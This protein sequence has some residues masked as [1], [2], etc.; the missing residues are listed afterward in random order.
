MGPAESPS[1]ATF[2]SKI[3]RPWNGLSYEAAEERWLKQLRNAWAEQD[4][5]DVPDTV[6][7]SIE[8]D[9]SPPLF[10][11]V[12]LILYSKET[13]EIEYENTVY[14]IE[15][16]TGDVWDMAARRAKLVANIYGEPG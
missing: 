3:G 7:H 13:G 11:I 14:K 9:E 1:F 4:H 10:T 8:V 16:A 2:H 6:E 12:S 15:R 5:S